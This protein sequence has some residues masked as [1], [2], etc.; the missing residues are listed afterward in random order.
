MIYLD[1][2]Y[3]QLRV[4][5]ISTEPHN[6]TFRCHL[7]MSSTGIFKR[8]PISVARV[9]GPDG[10]SVNIL[11]VAAPAKQPKLIP[12]GTRP[13]QSIVHSFNP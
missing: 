11:G 6:V 9:S 2:C 10:F 5:L 8:R 4:L 12:P 7:W 1:N 3:C 13:S